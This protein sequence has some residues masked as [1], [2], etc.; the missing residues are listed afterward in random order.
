VEQ[1]YWELGVEVLQL[2]EQLLVVSEEEHLL[3]RVQGGVV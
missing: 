2:E 1:T 3:L